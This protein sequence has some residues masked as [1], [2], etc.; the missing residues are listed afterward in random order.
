MSSLSSPSSGNRIPFVRRAGAIACLL[1][2]IAIHGQAQSSGVVER[3]LAIIPLPVMVKQY[4]GEFLI[5]P[6]TKLVS[7]GSRSDVVSTV[8]YLS[9]FL[10]RSTGFKLS[11]VSKKDRRASDII[12]FRLI[13]DGR[14]GNEG[15]LLDV[16]PSMIDIRANSSA[17]LF[18]AVQ[19]LLQILPPEVFGYTVSQGVEWNVPAVSILDRPRFPWR[20]MHLDVCRHFF[21][22]E[23]IKKYIDDIA[24]YKMN[25][26]HWHLTD[27][28]G[29]R[30][31]IK[32]YP[33]LTKVGAWRNGSMIG[34]Y[35][36]QKFDSIRYG[37]YYTQGDIREIVAYA[38][39]RHVTVV[40]E[41]EMPGH[42]MAALASYPDLSCTGG[43]FQVAESWGVFDDVFC[44]TEKTFR[45]LDNVL[46][47]VCKLFPGKYI[48]IGGDECPKVRWIDSRYCQRLMKR[49]RVRNPNQ[50]QSY[51]VK[52]IERFLNSKGKQVIGWDEILEGGL[53]P[54]AA[55]MSWRGTRG[56]IAA[57]KKRHYVV[58][59]PGSHCYFDYYQGNPEYEPLAIGGYTT[60]E[61]VYSYE[62][63]PSELSA[64]RAKY[65]LGA[66][67]NMWTEYVATPEH[68]E[69]M[70]FPRMIA[71]SEVDWTPAPLRDYA[72]F[73]RRLIRHFTIL[74]SMHVNY[75][76]S[77]YEI[78]IAVSS[79]ASTTGV[80][81]RLS[82]SF[83]SGGIHYTLDGSNPSPFSPLY[84]SPIAI[85][86]NVTARFAYFG[87]TGTLQGHVMDQSFVVSKSTGKPI[88][89]KVPPHE[90]YPGDGPF[91]L[92]DGIRGDPRHY[93][94][95]WLGFWGPNLDATIDLGNSNSYSSVTVGLLQLE[96]S[97]I[98]LPKSIEI[99]VGDD[100]S[101]FHSV[102]RVGPEEIAA[103]KDVMTI[104]IGKQTAR[105]IRVLEQN[106][107]R[108]PDGKP[109]GGS[110]SWLF[111]DEISVN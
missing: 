33:L 59:S 56:G 101:N 79:L 92:V 13:H 39:S 73:R 27:D 44:P 107:G 54:R 31:E 40:P 108:I 43:P 100:T 19:S 32:R 89:L 61:K 15:Y 62:P 95:N 35:S 86:K 96:V 111:V 66:Q 38:K 69:Y 55:V 26:F 72:D 7:V 93:G 83:D 9:D 76:K 90:N 75:A 6:S 85:E 51:F 80:A 25:V 22:K 94:K 48:H 103:A 68:V 82:T 8:K 84:T 37:G 3:P 77:I 34:P 24:M 5:G 102:K 74:D 36:D 20:G 21:P 30:I 28:Q 14:L 106:A 67:G 98:Y 88:T 12:M 78:Q 17:G 71:L 11:I 4:P 42:S 23:F 49:L 52:R 29:W 105:Y 87:N 46:A 1:I 91:T 70:I 41:I 97:W 50:L 18:Y 10:Q 109:G 64:T 60:V 58:M 45:F 53:A 81:L 2:S 47:E 65:I 110:A 99:F 57:A 63:V 16:S 104:D